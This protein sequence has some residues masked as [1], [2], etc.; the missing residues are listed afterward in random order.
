VSKSTKCYTQDLEL[1]AAALKGDSV[2][3]K[4]LNSKECTDGTY[5]RLDFPFDQGKD[6]YGYF[7][8]TANETGIQVT[9]HEHEQ[10]G[11]VVLSWDWQRPTKVVV[12]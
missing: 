4:C 9:C 5:I 7:M 10:D 11:R 12:K 3:R 1:L 2:A 6:K 8:L